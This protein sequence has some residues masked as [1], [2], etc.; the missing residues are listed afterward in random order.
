MGY[1][2]NIRGFD[3]PA[4]EALKGL[5]GGRISESPSRGIFDTSLNEHFQENTAR[6]SP[7]LLPSSD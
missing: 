1:R 6:V 3:F 5:P 7:A 4:C 2:E